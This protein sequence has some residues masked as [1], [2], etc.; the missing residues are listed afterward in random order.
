MNLSIGKQIFLVCLVLVL[1]FTGL[2]IY[3]YFQIDVSQESYSEVFNR[4]VPLMSGV[5]DLNIELKSQSSLVRAYILSGDAKY[6]EEYDSSRQRMNAGLSNLEQKLITPEGKKHISELKTALSEYHSMADQAIIVRKEKGQVEAAKFVS[7]AG[8]KSQA[9]EQKMTDTV[10]FLNERMQLRMQQANDSSNNMQLVVAII[11]IVLFVL[12]L[13]AAIFL[14]RR[15][16]RPLAAVAA[17][18]QNIAA[19]DLRTSS[20]SYDGNDEIADLIQ[21][22]SKMTANLR[23]LVQ[24][25][26]DS[27][28]HVAATSE[29]LA[30]SAE[31]SSQASNQVASSIADTAE[32]TQRQA[33]TVD[34][35]FGLVQQINEGTQE[36]AKGAEAAAEIAKK[37]VGAAQKGSIAVDTTIQQMNNIEEK[38][39]NSALLIGIL[40]E[41]SKSIGQIVDTISGIAGQTNLLA[42]NAAIEA[43][44]AGDQGRGFAVVADEV[45]KL[46]EQSQLAAKQISELISAIQTDTEQAVSA[47]ND[48]TQE[49]KRGSAVV[50]TASEAFKEIAGYIDSVALNIQQTNNQLSRLTTVSQEVV[51]AVQSIKD[52]SQDISGEA[53][54]VS[55]ATEEQLASMQEIAA[56]SRTLSSMADDL[57]HQV[58]QFTI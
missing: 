36:G 42:L 50:V 18:A 37:A 54:T 27:S 57:Q 9:A 52:I 22:F 51:G 12:A 32:G 14:A 39:T 41:R 55:A 45:R 1:A 58:K 26:G 38:V 46:A 24:Q 10:K 56:S 23:S 3:T 4:S 16:S 17:S 25:I 34:A 33:V 49:V 35:A 40:G 7:S 31:Q 11:D 2:N 19:G 29:Q 21:A 48:G 15:I 28:A 44:R 53:Q 47:M 5:K 8:V 30:A 43:A 20:I 6:A 13:G